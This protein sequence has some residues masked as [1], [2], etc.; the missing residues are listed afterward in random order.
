MTTDLENATRD[1]GFESTEEFHSLV[2]GFDLSTTARRKAFKTWQTED[3]T[4]A[5]LLNIDLIPKAGQVQ[6]LE[7][8]RQHRQTTAE[9]ERQLEDFQ[10]KVDSKFAHLRETLELEDNVSVVNRGLS[11]LSLLVN[12]LESGTQ[13]NLIRKDGEVLILDMRSMRSVKRGRSCDTE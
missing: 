6:N 13:I 5:G 12:E 11:L 4:K 1:L 9:A 3:G 2:A 8:Y 7:L 10:A